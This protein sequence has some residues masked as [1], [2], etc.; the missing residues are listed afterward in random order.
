MEQR[1]SF[2]AKYRDWISIKKLKIDEETG[3][4]E[5]VYILLSIYESCYRKAKELL[6]SFFPVEEIEREVEKR[7]EGIPKRKSISNLIKGLQAIKIRTLP[8]D[9]KFRALVEAVALEKL[10]DHFGYN[11]RIRLEPFAK[12]TGQKIPMKRRRR[13]KGP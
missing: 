5:I 11:S 2:I 6:N 1:I 8:G 10:F 3:L 13:K 7:L 9:E 4:E 12:A